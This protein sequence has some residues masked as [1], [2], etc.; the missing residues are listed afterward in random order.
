MPILVINTHTYVISGKLLKISKII[1]V[2]NTDINAI[3][4][5][6]INPK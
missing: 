5:P 4:N 3:L 1:V 2:A 6:L